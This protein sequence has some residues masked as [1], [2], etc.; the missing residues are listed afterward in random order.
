MF[1]V[2]GNVRVFS[3]KKNHVKVINIYSKNKFLRVVKEKK[4][5]RGYYYGVFGGG[6]GFR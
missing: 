1:F 6:C 5:Y 2:S 3:K 4:M